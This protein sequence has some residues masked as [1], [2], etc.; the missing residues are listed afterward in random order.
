MDNRIVSS[1]T[2]TY[3]TAN[4]GCSDTTSETLTRGLGDAEIR[5]SVAVDATDDW[6]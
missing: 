2:C 6:Y 3:D 4:D 1:F 5:T